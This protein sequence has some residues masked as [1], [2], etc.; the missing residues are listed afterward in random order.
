MSRA[1]CR[2]QTKNAAS[3][4]KMR[5]ADKKNFYSGLSLW[6]RRKPAGLLVLM[7]KRREAALHKENS[8]EEPP[9]MKEKKRGFY[10]S[11]HSLTA[12]EILKLCTLGTTQGHKLTVF[13]FV[14]MMRFLSTHI[15]AKRGNAWRGA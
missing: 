1:A 13:F 4:Q 12:M 8:N 6:P 11:I 5:R 14:S 7:A 10:S 15:T 3:R 2:E 9:D